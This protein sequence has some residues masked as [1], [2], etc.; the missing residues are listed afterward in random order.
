MLL[1]W[2]LGI[3]AKALLV[4]TRLMIQSGQTIERSISANGPECQ[5]ILTHKLQYSVQS[6]Y[7]W[8][9]NVGLTW[10]LEGKGSAL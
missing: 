6:A 1:P 7:Q 10:P 4:L 9:G 8:L 3:F 5:Q 2:S